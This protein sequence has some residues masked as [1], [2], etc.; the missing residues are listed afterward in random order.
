MLGMNL[1][2]EEIQ[3]LKTLFEGE[4]SDEEISSHKISEKIDN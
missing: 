1:S 3:K 4:L 2:F